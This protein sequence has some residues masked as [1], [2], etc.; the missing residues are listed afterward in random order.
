MCVCTTGLHFQF[1]LSCTTNNCSNDR[2]IGASRS[3]TDIVFLRKIQATNQGTNRITPMF[4]PR[5]YLLGTTRQIV[6]VLATKA[7]ERVEV[8]LRSFLTTA[9]DGGEWSA[10]GPSRFTP[11]VRGPATHWIVVWSGPILGWTNFPKVYEPAPISRPQ[12]GDAKRFRK[13]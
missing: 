9:V 12:N 3:G 7:Y 1:S 2:S 8:E 10:P 4:S 13:E 11:E 6:P 5:M